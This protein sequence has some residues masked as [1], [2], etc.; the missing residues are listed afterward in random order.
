[1]KPKHLPRLWCALQ[2]LLPLETRP[3]APRGELAAPASP[4][5]I[6]NLPIRPAAMRATSGGRRMEGGAV[7]PPRLRA[8]GG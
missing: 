4:P 5:R 6:A 2:G 8:M 7:L 3:V 1:M